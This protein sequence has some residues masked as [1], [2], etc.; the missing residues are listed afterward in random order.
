[1]RNT[2]LIR[3]LSVWVLVVPASSFAQQAPYT[4][5]IGLAVKATFDQNRHVANVELTNITTN[6]ITAYNLTLHTIY[7]DGTSSDREMLE[8]FVSSLPL[9]GRVPSTRNQQIGAIKPGATRF[10]EIAPT[11]RGNSPEATQG[12]EIQPDAVVFSDSTTT[13]PN[14]AALD[15]IFAYRTERRDSLRAW[16]E[17]LGDSAGGQADRVEIF[18]ELR[19]KAALAGRKAVPANHVEQADQNLEA[20]QEVFRREVDQGEQRVRT[21]RLSAAEWLQSYTDSVR[22]EYELFKLHAHRAG[23][24]HHSRGYFFGAPK[25]RR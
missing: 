17:A 4:S 14:G 6:P 18:G 7:S 11:V 16:L 25:G 20:W 5:T 2:E 10:L 22:Q 15:R 8:D 3:F 1:M 12:L 21:R 23:G 24:D 9:E 13:G 19:R